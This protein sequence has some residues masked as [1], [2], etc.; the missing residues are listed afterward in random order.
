MK[1]LL[2]KSY[3]ISLVLIP[4]VAVLLGKEKQMGEVKLWLLRLSEEYL[5]SE[6]RK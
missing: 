6:K 5:E 4:Q 3:G 1:I 2:E